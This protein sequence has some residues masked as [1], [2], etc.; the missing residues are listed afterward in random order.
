MR[1]TF[2]LYTVGFCKDMDYYTAFPDTVEPLPFLKMSNYPYGEDEGFP[3][4]EAHRRYRAEW[5]T[6]RVEPVR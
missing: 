6:R 5:N 2:M 1:R 4:D 3:D